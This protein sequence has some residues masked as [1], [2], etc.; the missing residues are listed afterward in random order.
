VYAETAARTTT[1]EDDVFVSILHRGGVRSHLTMSSLVG[2]PGPRTRV[3]GSA[4]AYVSTLME[5]EPA[6]FLGFEDAPGYCGWLVTGEERRPVPQPPGTSVDFYRA[7]IAALALPNPAARQ[8]AMPVDPWDA[9]AV[10]EVIDAARA[11]ASATRPVA[12]R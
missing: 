12:L 1:A 10:A 2:A 11:S 5:G 4:G 8:P 7:V 3:L 9:V 6:A